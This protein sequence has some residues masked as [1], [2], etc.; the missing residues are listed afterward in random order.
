MEEVF[1]LLFADD[2]ANLSDTINRLQKQIK[3]LELFC[4]YTGMDVNV[5]KTKITVFRNGGIL[6]KMKNGS[7]EENPLK[8]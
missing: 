8:S 1:C 2:V 7:I 4:D 3:I 6:K 5:N